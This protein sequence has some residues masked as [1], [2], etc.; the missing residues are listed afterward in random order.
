MT[1]NIHILLMLVTQ[2]KQTMNNGVAMGSPLGPSLANGFLGHYEQ[3]WLDDCP[4]EFKPVYYK[5]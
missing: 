1:F 2:I 4:D 5:R 3:V